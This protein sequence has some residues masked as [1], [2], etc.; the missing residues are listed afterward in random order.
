M[1][2][3]KLTEGTDEFNAL[4]KAWKVEAKEISIDEL[5]EFL[6]A[7]AN[8]YEHDYGTICHV[9]AIAAIAGANAMNKSPQGGI[10]GFQGN[11][12]MWEFVR[13]WMYS[14]NKVGLRIVDYDNLLYPQYASNFKLSITS[15]T[16]A[17]LQKAAS[18]LIIEADTE[19]EKY[20]LDAGA[21]N[22]DLAN[23]IRKYPDYYERPEH[24]D[25]IGGGNI[26]QWD[27]Y[28]KKK[29]SGFEFAPRKPSLCVNPTVYAHWSAI[30]AGAVPFGLKVV[31]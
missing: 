3:Q 27:A 5:P 28:N 22:I 13:E 15:E 26:D 12:V 24:Y 30:V 16:Q 1:S 14:S 23:F 18:E 9:V 4:V 7:I 20:L 21:Y 29:E 19:R 25:H 8:N 11:A 10:T 31:A 6:N 2:K 17:A